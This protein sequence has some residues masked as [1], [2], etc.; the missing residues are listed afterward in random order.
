MCWLS[1]LSTAWSP[2]SGSVYHEAD[3]RL[4]SP[5][6]T[7]G[8][9]PRPPR[10]SI[11]ACGSRAVQKARVR[12]W[13]SVDGTLLW[14]HRGVVRSFL[15]WKN[16]VARAQ[17]R[18]QWNRHVLA[19]GYSNHGSNVRVRPTILRQTPTSNA[20]ALIDRAASCFRCSPPRLVRPVV[21]CVSRRSASR[22]RVRGRRW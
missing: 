15:H 13:C 5:A 12:N 8:C 1:V 3:L 19:P 10:W 9:R 2:C 21:T 6:Q 14:H 20:L 4:P 18:H 17:V 22:R 7:A 16:G 11:A